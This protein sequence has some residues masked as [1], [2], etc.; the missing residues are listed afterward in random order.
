MTAGRMT[1]KGGSVVSNTARGGNGG[2]VGLKG[3]GGNGGNAYGGGVH[4]AADAAIDLIDAAIG[5]F[6]AGNS[7][8]GGSAGSGGFLGVNGTNGKGVGGGLFLTT[9]GSTKRNTTVAFNV[10]STADNDIHGPITNV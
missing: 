2:S 5:A 1:Y 9:A 4:V 8:I 10:A 3:I 6:F 7:A